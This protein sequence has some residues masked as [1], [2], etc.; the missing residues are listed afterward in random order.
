MAEKNTKIYSKF[1]EN[2]NQQ[3]IK[4]VKHLN[5]PALVVAGPGSGKTKVLTHRVAYLINHHKVDPTNILCVTFTNKAAQ[6]MQLRIAKLLK[7]KIKLSFIGTFHSISSRILRKDGFHAGISISYVIYDQDDS[8][9]VI[10]N[11]IKDFGIDS[12]NIKPTS[13]A[14]AISGAKAELVGPSEYESSAYGYF[15]KT[16]AKIYYEYQKRLK[17]NNALDFDDLLF[18]LV[19]LFRAYPNVLEKYQDQFQHILVDE[20]QDTN[21]AQYVLTKMLAQKNKNLYV[22]GDMSQAIYSFR[23]ADYR[24]ILNF[25]TDYKDVLIYNLEQNYRSTQNILDAAKNVIKNNSTHISLDLWTT[26]GEG[27]KLGNFLGFSEYEEAEFVAN[28]TLDKIKHG[29]DFR[30]IAVLYRTNAQSRNLEEHFIKNNIPY[31]IIGGLRFYSRKEVKD[32]TAYLRIIHN[33]KDSVS[34]ERVIN[35]PP[36]KIGQK[37]VEILKKN[38]WDIDEVEEKSNL[39]IKKW[40]G[41]KENLST[42][43]LMDMVLDDTK[44]LDFLNDGTDEGQYRIENIKE[45]RTV[46]QKFVKLEDFLE[47]VSLIESSNKAEPDK[48]HAV[49]LMTIHASK[50]LEF[51]VIF[52]IGMEEGLFPHSQSIMEKE[53]IE[54]ER[55]LCYV[56]ITRAKEKVFFTR[57]SSRMYFGLRQNNLP[58]RFLL[59]IPG[60]ILESIGVKQQNISSTSFDLNKV[61]DDLEFDRN[62]FSW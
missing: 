52:I 56:A 31:K 18:E 39:P 19:K 9:S 61:L 5:G 46:A 54:E 43:E 6:E 48:Y 23:G 27:D 32:I 59:E 11:I 60:E 16:T 47:N 49:T 21:K 22:V 12:K 38:K 30:D 8:L 55:R 2:L 44:Y 20:Y 34:W 17:T 58:S 28:Q 40:I 7:G 26:Q 53:E 50:G 14:N 62:N 35:V 33:P 3:Q 51:P 24:N 13:V 4:A 25:Q 41:Q 1:F 45:L 36:R 37:S 15:Y 57:A 29:H 42:L 10:K